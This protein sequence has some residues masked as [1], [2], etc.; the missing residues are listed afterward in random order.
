VL[1]TT[2]KLVGRHIRD[3]ILGLCSLHRYQYAYKP[4]KSTESTVYHV[5]THRE[6]AV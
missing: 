3:E 6:E 1:K 2:E 5:I 4:G